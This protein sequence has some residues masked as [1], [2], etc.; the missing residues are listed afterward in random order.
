MGTL[1]SWSLPF[2][3]SRVSPPQT[4]HDHQ[5]MILLPLLEKQ[6]HPG[7]ISLSGW[8]E[9]GGPLLPAW[10]NKGPRGHVEWDWCCP[11]EADRSRPGNR[12]LLQGHKKCEEAGRRKS[13]NLYGASEKASRR[14]GDL[15][16]KWIE[17]CCFPAQKW[18]EGRRVYEA[19][20]N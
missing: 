20:A 4:P 12:Y 3:I 11:I 17:R 1:A 13:S 9:R 16:S 18:E 19:E 14:L 10:G 8:G 15:R 6:A 5:G 2:K 7:P